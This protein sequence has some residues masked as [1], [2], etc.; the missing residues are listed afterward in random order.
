M[1]LPKL[2][3]ADKGYGDGFETPSGLLVIGDGDIPAR[4]RGNL[5]I[6]IQRHGQALATGGVRASVPP[7]PNR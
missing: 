6:Y 2:G 5:V 1:D 3:G 4:A 7:P